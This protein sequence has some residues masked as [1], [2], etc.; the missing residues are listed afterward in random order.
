MAQGDPM[1][2]RLRG[3]WSN[4]WQAWTCLRGLSRLICIADDLAHMLHLPARWLCDLHDGRLMRTMGEDGKNDLHNETIRRWWDEGEP[5][6]LATGPRQRA[7]DAS[8]APG[9]D[10]YLTYEQ[11]QGLWNTSAANVTT[12]LGDVK[13]TYRSTP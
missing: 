7:L 8:V 3:W 2:G 1:I 12:T 5:V 11:A 6:E 13:V 10:I 9:A 4:H